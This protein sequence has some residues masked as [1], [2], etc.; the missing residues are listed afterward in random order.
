MYCSKAIA[1]FRGRMEPSWWGWWTL[2][3]RGL[4][5]GASRV[6]AYTSSEEFED[7]HEEAQGTKQVEQPHAKQILNTRDKDN[8]HCKGISRTAWELAAASGTHETTTCWA[9]SHWWRWRRCNQMNHLWFL[10][11]TAATSSPPMKNTLL[12]LLRI[13]VCAHFQLQITPIIYIYYPV[14]GLSLLAEYR[15]GLCEQLSNYSKCF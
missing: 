7:S 1:W 13:G 5:L 9:A 12:S 4:R 3:H 2:K 8:T 6:S 14:T 10:L 15:G 11:L